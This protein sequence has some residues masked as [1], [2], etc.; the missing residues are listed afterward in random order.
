MSRKM[1]LLGF[2]LKNSLLPVQLLFCLCDNAMFI[3]KD[4]VLRLHFRLEDKAGN[5]KNT[6][7]FAL[8]KENKIQGKHRDLLISPFCSHAKPPA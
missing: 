4:T 7:T 6:C 1:S 3:M 2:V 8:T 5:E